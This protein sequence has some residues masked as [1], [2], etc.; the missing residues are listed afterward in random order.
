MYNVSAAVLQAS[1]NTLLAHFLSLV[2]TLWLVRIVGKGGSPAGG[3][4]QPYPA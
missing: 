4:G 3:K 1:T 2:F